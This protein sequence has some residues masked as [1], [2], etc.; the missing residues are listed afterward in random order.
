LTSPDTVAQD[1]LALEARWGAHNYAALEA[2]IT[3]DTC[4]F[5]VE[6][7]QGE[8]GIVLPPPLLIE[9]QD[10]RWLVPEIYAVLGK[11]PA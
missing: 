11:E 7:I 9:E 3:P 6:P 5:L 1:L 4:A 10:L 2:A 8:A